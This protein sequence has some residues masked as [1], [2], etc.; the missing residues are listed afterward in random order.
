[1][2][3]GQTKSFID[4]RWW[5]TKFANLVHMPNLC[6]C[7][8]TVLCALRG[9]LHNYSLLVHFIIS[10]SHKY[11]TQQRIWNSLDKCFW[12]GW[13][14]V[15][16]RCWNIFRLVCWGKM[17]HKGCWHLEK[18]SGLFGECRPSIHKRGSYPTDSPS[19]YEM[20]H[21]CWLHRQWGIIEVS[22]SC[23][24]VFGCFVV[25]LLFYVCA[26]WRRLLIDTVLFTVVEIQLSF[27]FLA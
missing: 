20:V 21:L 25:C 14:I 23:R 17:Y 1:M 3:A 16:A 9:G 7:W 2:F 8:W 24:V 26:D 11:W 19:F 12:F 10:Y 6:C 4:F 27:F 22:S 15:S 18:W 13:V 5:T